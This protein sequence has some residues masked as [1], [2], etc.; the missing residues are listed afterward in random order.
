MVDDFSGYKKGF[1][2]PTIE[3]Y[4]DWLQVQITVATGPGIKKAINYSLKSW[5]TLVR[6]LDDG[7]VPMDNNHI[8]QQIRPIAL[9][10]RNWLPIRVLG[11]HLQVIYFIV[12]SKPSLNSVKPFTGFLLL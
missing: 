1:L 6:Y 4:H 9:V 2:D 8:E 11:G 7:A 3:K 5:D 10:R 12:T